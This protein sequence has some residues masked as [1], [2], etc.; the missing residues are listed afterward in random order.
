MEMNFNIDT[1]T[2]MNNYNDITT[3]D[4]SCSAVSNGNNCDNDIDNS[5][6]RKNVETDAH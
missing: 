2:E 3:V 4:E 1:K 6:N 5:N